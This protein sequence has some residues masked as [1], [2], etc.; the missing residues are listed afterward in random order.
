LS[1]GCI[2]YVYY[3]ENLNWAA[4]RP[5]VGHSWAKACCSTHV[6]NWWPAGQMWPAKLK[7]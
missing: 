6:S 2:G 3:S 4:C 1:V 7:F 5:R